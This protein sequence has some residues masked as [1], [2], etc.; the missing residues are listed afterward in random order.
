MSNGANT[1]ITIFLH[2]SNTSGKKWFTCA[3]NLLFLL[4]VGHF[5]E[6]VVLMT[7]KNTHTHIQSLKQGSE[8]GNL[9]RKKNS[10][11]SPA[12]LSSTKKNSEIESVA[13]PRDNWRR[14][15]SSPQGFQFLINIPKKYIDVS[16]QTNKKKAATGKKKKFLFV[17]SRKNPFLLSCPSR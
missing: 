2:I 12:V 6:Q 16:K 9:V 8:V 3:V 4:R 13:K 14:Y 15:P 10:S 7:P 1:I 17:S 11:E 5:F